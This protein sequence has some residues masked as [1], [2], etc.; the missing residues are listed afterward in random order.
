[1]SHSFVVLYDLD[2]VFGAPAFQ[3]LR[4][5][6]GF[7]RVPLVQAAVRFQESL[8]TPIGSRAPKEPLN[9]LALIGQFRSREIQREPAAEIQIVLV[10]YGD[11]P[12]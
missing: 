8:E 12:V 6:F 2:P 3:G 10:R 9:R 7:E 11:V 4:R 1:M 5:G